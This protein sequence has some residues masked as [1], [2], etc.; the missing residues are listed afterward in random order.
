MITVLNAEFGVMSAEFMSAQHS[1]L[2]THH[3]IL[4]WS[5]RSDS[6]RRLQVYK[7]R[8]VA[9]EAQGRRGSAE[10][11][12]QSE[13]R[14]SSIFTFCTLHSQT[15]HL[16]LALSRGVAPRT[17]AFAERRAESDYT[18]RAKRAWMSE[19]LDSSNWACSYFDKNKMSQFPITASY[20]ESPDHFVDAFKHAPKPRR[21]IYYVFAPFVG[22]PVAF[23]A[24]SDK[25]RYWHPFWP[26]W[27]LF[28]VGLYLFY[29]S[30]FMQRWQIRRY[31]KKKAKG[32]DQV[33]KWEFQEADI[34]H[35]TGM[36]STRFSWSFMTKVTQLE[37][38][39]LLYNPHK[40][41]FWIPKSSLTCAGDFER[42]AELFTR[43]VALIERR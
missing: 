42:L 6:H 26:L 30:G 11:G 1:A 39:F 43:K 31:F 27:Y 41:F 40:Q 10:W 23:V 15:L 14:Q 13:N 19:I 28:G 36:S 17:S 3:S 5:P 7:T 21:W 38:G 34:L 20:V 32:Q 35:F 9:A 33:V 2:C 37:D 25:N 24:Y 29:V 18:L 22:V 16:K 8:P 4:N 12:V